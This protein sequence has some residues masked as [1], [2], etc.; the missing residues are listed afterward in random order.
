M[1]LSGL[2]LMPHRA[3]GLKE[4]VWWWPDDGFGCHRIEVL[5]DLFGGVDRVESLLSNKFF[6][7]EVEDVAVATLMFEQGTV[8][9]LTIAHS[10]REPQDPLDIF[11]TDGSIHVPVLNDGRLKVK[12][13][14]GEREE[15]HPPAA[16]IHQPLIDDF[17]L[18]VLENRDPVVSGDNGLAVAEVQAQMS[19]KL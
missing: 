17:A 19:D 10:A 16:N 7:R 15:F 2:M 18:A 1:L 12:T 8:A 6:K 14:D 4:K 11:G 9:T 5:L 3:R 13:I